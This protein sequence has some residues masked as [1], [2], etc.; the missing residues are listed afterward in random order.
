MKVPVPPTS[1]YSTLSPGFREIHLN[2]MFL[3]MLPA[4]LVSRVTQEK[5]T[6]AAEY[7]ALLKEFHEYVLDAPRPQRRRRKRRKLKDD[8]ELAEK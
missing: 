2:E 6:T 3:D 5:I 4:D 8:Q 7:L 1:S